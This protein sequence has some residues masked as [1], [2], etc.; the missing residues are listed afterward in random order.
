M[1]VDMNEEKRR[2]KTKR[3]RRIDMRKREK[4]MLFL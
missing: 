1:K 2:T 3:L 4:R